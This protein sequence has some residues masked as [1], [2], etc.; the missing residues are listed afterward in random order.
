MVAL[1]TVLFVMFLASHLRASVEKLRA[2]RNHV[3]ATYY[4]NLWFVCILNLLRCGVQ[5]WQA[6]PLNHVRLWNALWLATRFGM[7][8]LEVSAVVYLYLAHGHSRA[9]GA[10]AALRETVV[11]A[12]GVAGIDLLAKSVLI[13]GFGVQVFVE[14]PGLHSRAYFWAKW[15]YWGARAFIAALVYG[16]LTALPR[17]R[18]RDWM[19]ARPSFYR[20]TGVLF[21]MY[22]VETVC[23]LCVGGGVSRW[24]Y[25]VFGLCNYA[26]Y[27]CYPPVLYLTFLA[28]YFR[29]DEYEVESRYYSEMEEAGYFDDLD[30]V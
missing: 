17:T 15:G 12:M 16:V 10:A 20:Y 22:A 9:V 26:Y 14:E 21:V 29:E 8:S 19:P 27:A 5:M 1:P 11:I 2:T 4:T 3:M 18:Y 23:A 7:D 30:D 28:D 6:S 13:F 24:A 25:C